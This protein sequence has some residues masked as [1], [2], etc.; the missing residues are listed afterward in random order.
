MLIKTK[1][2]MQDFDG[3]IKKINYEYSGSS[4]YYNYIDVEINRFFNQITDFPEAE[5][6]AYFGNFNFSNDFSGEEINNYIFNYL[7]AL[8]I[9]KNKATDILQ[10]LIPHEFNRTESSCPTSKIFYLFWL[11]FKWFNVKESKITSNLSDDNFAIMLDNVAN[12]MDQHKSKFFILNKNPYFFTELMLIRKKIFTAMNSTPL[13]KT[14]F[15]H[16]KTSSL[17]KKTERVSVEI[18]SLH[19]TTNNKDENTKKIKTAFED[20]NIQLIPDT[21]ST[22]NSS[23]EDKKTVESKTD[24]SISVPPPPPPPPSPPLIQDN[25]HA[26]VIA[27][28]TAS[29][30]SSLDNLP[31]S[32]DNDSNN[33]LD[34]SI[35]VEKANTFSE[36]HEKEE[37]QIVNK[38]KKIDPRDELLS[39]IR[40]SN[41]DNLKSIVKEQNIDCEKIKEEA[42]EHS[43][44]IQE[45]LSQIGKEAHYE[46]MKE[47]LEC[48]LEIMNDIVKQ[49]PKIDCLQKEE[50]VKLE[51]IRI[52]KEEFVERGEPKRSKTLSSFKKE[53]KK[54]KVLLKTLEKNLSLLINQF[55][56]AVF[57]N[58]ASKYIQLKIEDKQ[59][60]ITELNDKVPANDNDTHEVQ[61]NHLKN[62]LYI[63]DKTIKNLQIA[64]KQD[65][66][67]YSQKKNL[68]GRRIDISVSESEDE[69][70]E[71][72][73][74]DNDAELAK[75]GHNSN[76]ETNTSVENFKRS[77]SFPNIYIFTQ[78]PN[79]EKNNLIRNRSFPN[80]NLTHQGLFV[81]STP[82]AYRSEHLTNSFLSKNN[83]RLSNTN[84]GD[85]SGYNTRSSSEN[86]DSE[87]ENRNNPTK[88]LNLCH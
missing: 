74:S 13:F 84:L 47:N 82:D 2:I 12:M 27:T 87:D 52:I 88:P 75:S 33:T 70:S 68:R 18:Q 86:M 45:T 36:K 5:L 61:V 22:L 30:S 26:K 72:E 31:L 21:L 29:V 67:K 65:L 39:M 9:Q 4:G 49:A 44:K 8:T 1:K 35:I 76:S 20:N 34:I 28:S 3:E 53:L 40:I 16:N 59:K 50:Q 69:N 57:I 32:K 55:E 37:I 78:E 83:T 38:F 14:G 73:W 58:T 43:I 64:L 11:I 54:E 60:I 41:K 6:A 25:K 42:I 62:Q 77:G 19:I 56:L 46:Q 24:T 23:F 17:D 85:S 48:Q 66:D 79:K 63:K 10:V 7:I 15:Q 81:T 71:D 80:V 51:H